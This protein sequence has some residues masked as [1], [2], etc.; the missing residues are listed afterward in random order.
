M[1]NP[2]RHDWLVPQSYTRRST[3]ATRNLSGV[4]ET[5]EAT[6]SLGGLD[7]MAV[8]VAAIASFIFGGVWYNVF[9]R[10]WMEALGR[11]PDTMPRDRGAVG[12]YVVA[13]LAQLI[14][15]WMLAGILLHLATGGLPT[16]LRTGV[17][18]AAFLW[19]GFV[20]TTMVVNYSFQ[21]ARHR[22]AVLDGAHWLGVLLIQGAILGWWGVR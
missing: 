11:T 6:M 20:I 17:I 16:T 19:F 1:G 12:L 22:L 4:Q 10:Q 18:S 21:G 8:I 7:Y 3:L 2:L 9:S 15:A 13:F 5:G 14:M